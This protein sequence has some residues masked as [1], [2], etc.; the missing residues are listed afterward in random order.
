MFSVHKSSR[1]ARVTDN[2]IWSQKRDKKVDTFITTF[3]RK[4][5]LEKCHTL[6]TIFE[7]RN[8]AVKARFFGHC[9]QMRYLGQKSFISWFF[10]T[11]CDHVYFYTSLAY[12]T[13]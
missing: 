13:N 6:I 9:D 8:V 7:S 2:Y 10:V 5:V 1:V 3:S 12:S 4:K 11:I